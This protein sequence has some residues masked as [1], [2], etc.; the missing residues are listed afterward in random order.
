MMLWL[1]STSPRRRQLLML[2][3]WI[4]RVQPA[5][6][7]ETTMLGEEARVYVQRLAE[8]KAR[9]VAEVAS[10]GDVIVG[11]D[12]AVVDGEQI[13]GKPVSPDEAVEML[14][15]LRGRSHQVLTALVVLRPADTFGHSEIC[16]KA[17]VATEVWMRQYSPAEVAAYVQSGDPLDKAGAYAIQHTGFHPVERLQGCYTNVVGLP[18]CR[19]ARMLALLGHPAVNPLPSAC[20]LRWE[21]VCD[22][23]V[24]MIQ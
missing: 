20:L 23:P 8:A 19:L 6:V 1:A 15:R 7:D 11:A 22:F 21:G 13:M 4:F 12:T 16:L 18:M 3:G 2:S 5:G 10:P 24:D 9:R 14:T 17:Q